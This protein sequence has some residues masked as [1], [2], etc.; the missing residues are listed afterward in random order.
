MKTTRNEA[1]YLVLGVLGGA[2]RGH[3][4]DRRM[5]THAVPMI[6]GMA[7]GGAN[8]PICRKVKAEKMADDFCAEPAGSVPTCPVCAE[9]LARLGGV[10][11]ASE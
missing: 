5:V 9:R 11:I 4:E 1:G 7:G 10:V 3:Q 8:A 2:Y 6:D